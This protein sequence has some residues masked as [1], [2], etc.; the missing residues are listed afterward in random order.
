MSDHFPLAQKAHRACDSTHKGISRRSLF[1]AAGAGALSFLLAPLQRDERGYAYAADP[2]DTAGSDGQDYPVF[3]VTLNDVGFSVRDVTGGGNAPKAGSV[4]TLTAPDGTTASGTTDEYGAVVIDISGVSTEVDLGSD[5]GVRKRFDGAVTVD[6]GND[7]RK[8]VI[9]RVRVDG[10]SAA[11]VPTRALESDADPYFQQISFDGWDVQYVETSFFNAESNT[12]RHTITCSL[13]M[14]MF[15]NAI[16]RLKSKTSDGIVDEKVIAS[17]TVASEHGIGSA[18]FSGNFLTPVSP[19]ALPLDRV[20]FLEVEAGGSVYT[21]DTKIGIVKAPIEEVYNPTSGASKSLGTAE[22]GLGFTFPDSWP[23]PFKSSKFSIWT[24]TLPIIYGISPCGAFLFG[25]GSPKAEMRNSANFLDSDDWKTESSKSVEQQISSIEKG[26]TDTYEKYQSMRTG[27]KPDG[28]KMDRVDVCKKLSLNVDVQAYA[29]MRYLPSDVMWKG[30]A[31]IIFQVAAKLSVT[32]TFT[33]GPIPMYVNIS[34]SMTAKLSGQVGMLSS[35]LNPLDWT[36]DY[37]QGQLAF[38]LTL[39][40]PITVGIGLDGIVSLGVRASGYISIFLGF[41]EAGAGK[42]ELP[43]AVVAGGVRTS[44]VVQLVLFKWSGTIWSYDNPSMYNSWADGAADIEA[45]ADPE[46]A[47][48]APVDGA[49]SLSSN[50][51]PRYSIEGPIG[52]TGIGMETFIESAAIVTE[53]ELRQTAE[54][55]AAASATDA[56]E[57]EG[58]YP[59]FESIAVEG[60]EAAIEGGNV[61]SDPWLLAGVEIPA[62]LGALD[63]YDYSYI[64]TP[65]DQGALTVGVEGIADQGGMR[66]TLDALIAQD[67]FSDPRQKIVVYKGQPYLFRLLNVDYGNDGARSRLAAQKFNLDTGQ[68]ESPVI[69]QF[70]LMVPDAYHGTTKNLARIDTFD[71]DF[72]IL[73]NEVESNTLQAGIYVLLSSGARPEGDASTL[74]QVFSS[75]VMT[76][77]R[78]DE[79]LACQIVRSWSIEKNQAGRYCSCSC[80]RLFKMTAPSAGKQ[81]D[82]LAVI[83]LSRYG[84]TPEATVPNDLEGSAAGVRVL[85]WAANALYGSLSLPQHRT[86]YDISGAGLDED[87]W[88][89]IFAR[90][91]QPYSNPDNPDQ[92]YA[93]ATSIT[94]LYIGS[95]HPFAGRFVQNVVN[96]TE[97]ENCVPWT[98]HSELLTLKQGILHAASFDKNTADCTLDSR[99]VGPSDIQMTTFR[100]SPD[101]NA[102]IYAENVEGKGGQEFDEHGN[103][104]GDIAVKRHRIMGS[105]FVEGL[106]STPFPIAELD[107]SIDSLSNISGGA[108]YDSYA[109]AYSIIKD[110]A[111]SRADVRFANV[112]AVASATPLSLVSDKEFVLAGST[113]EKFTMTIRNDGNV[114]ITGCCVEFRDSNTRGLVNRKDHFKFESDTVVASIWNPELHDD[115]TGSTID[116]EPHYPDEAI[117]A[118]GVEGVHVLANPVSSGALL[119]GATST[120]RIEFPIPKDWRGTKQTY[121]VLKDFRYIIPGTRLSSEADGDLLQYSLPHDQCPTCEF[122]VQQSV[123]PS[124]DGLGDA[125]VVKNGAPAGEGENPND[126]HGDGQKDGDHAFAQTGDRGGLAVA[127][128]VAT[129][130]AAGFA[131]YSARRHAIECADDDSDQTS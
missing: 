60:S 70:P 79:A 72:D 71:Y 96:S 113:A 82:I 87:G 125:I 53:G 115:G 9:G 119:P 12:E 92:Q 101:G 98:G 114:I 67:V 59:E 93:S 128:L 3:V 95:F 56:I 2:N 30:T 68:A 17:Q 124:G 74:A 121:I 44:V 36:F 22:S 109:F 126:A 27:L 123:E 78:F 105:I 7:Y 52:G 73:A 107:H 31:A 85:A 11:Q 104:A 18:S 24:P 102:V 64:G 35:S 111:T 21:V 38:T 46:S 43:H 75:P 65:P 80:P 1:A 34:P 88:L 55:A 10:G 112:P 61:V 117:A 91:R 14:P 83:Y 4:V 19:N 40:V 118:T 32:T 127:G 33:I 62:G 69:L 108:S 81:H 54:F 94:S 103:A 42:R 8:V 57:L 25:V 16:V 116:V 99:Q 39:D 120:Y 90:S 48:Q 97:L 63:G 58:L 6:S 84:A 5:K 77:A 37:T 51:Q 66:P 50:D 23:P 20:I 45:L 106:F 13:W 130:A 100:I 47:S 49:F 129:A 28:S 131:A 122:D 26:F 15:K 29:A 41:Y 110:M 76:L 89:A 86:T